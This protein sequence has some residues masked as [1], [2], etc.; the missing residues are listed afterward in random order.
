MVVLVARERQPVAL[1]GVADEADRT[2]VVDLAEGL[3]QGG[4]V[5][6][7]QVGHQ[8]RELVVAASLDQPRD[9]ALVAEVVGE[10]LA[11]R[12]AALEHQGRIE[13][14]GAAV[15]PVAQARPA[16]LRESGFQQRTVFQDDDV[17]AEGA[18]QLFVAFPQTLAHHGVEALAVVVDDPPAIAQALLPAFQH[19]LE[20]VALVELGVAHQRHH[21]ALGALA[22]PA[23]RPHIVLRQRGE[24]R[25]RHPETDRAGG[26]I[27]VV[28][29]LGARRI[30]LRALV[31]A[32]AFELLAGLAAEQ[33]LDRMKVRTRMR[34]HGDAVLRLEHREIER[35]HD[36]GERG[37]R[38]LMAADLEAVLALSHV[39]G[40]M[41]GPGR[42]PQH[43]LLERAQ[44][45]E[46]AGSGRR[47][48]FFG[49]LGRR[50]GHAGIMPSSAWQGPPISITIECQIGI[51]GQNRPQR[52]ILHAAPTGRPRPQDSR[53]AADR[54]AHEPCRPRRQGG[55]LAVALPAPGPHAGARRR[56]RALRRGARS[57]GRR[58]AGER[59]RVGQAG[60]PARAG[61]RTLR[62]GDRALA[63]G[64]RVL[65]DDRP[66]RLLAAR[67]GARP[68]R[69]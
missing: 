4:Q 7:R 46:R 10:P 9:V 53:P 69:L 61:A 28:D 54:R 62:Q 11:P 22:P 48:P 42:E 35:R 31:A 3:E 41:D 38:G 63:R 14:V 2:V 36:G 12:R 8:P 20:D 58:V 67:G 60:A 34:L 57:A 43:L 1:D 68:R 56:H 37:R 52:V 30:A 15:D 29:V 17:P 25:L 66:A 24:E 55:A 21:A 16:R 45:R 49:R 19:G 59:L 23:M 5:V 64:A 32:K 33:I 65:P 13:L 27:D 47:G 18:K 6:A 40:V 50:L 44:Q 26:E 51:F 39:V